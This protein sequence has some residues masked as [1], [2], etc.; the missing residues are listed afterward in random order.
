MIVFSQKSDK[1]KRNPNSLRKLFIDIINE[2]FDGNISR[3][4][5]WIENNFPN[6]YGVLD[7]SHRTI[8]GQISE[9][10]N[11]I[12]YIEYWHIEAFAR[13]VGVPAGMLLIFSRFRSEVSGDSS[14]TNARSIRDAL[15]RA[16]SR[17]NFS[18]ELHVGVLEEWADSIK[19]YQPG[20]DLHIR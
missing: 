13:M 7:K 3:A 2:K 4:A 5:R 19:N 11:D 16:M 8:R 12:R 15:H 1:E 18:D 9:I 14:L 10:V 17:T 20:L 6:N